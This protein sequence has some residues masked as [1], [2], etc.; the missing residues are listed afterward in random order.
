MYQLL[1]SKILKDT[2]TESLLNFYIN[3]SAKK[4]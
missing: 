4:C 3:R 2:D 1:A